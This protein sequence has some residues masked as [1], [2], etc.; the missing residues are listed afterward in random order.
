MVKNNKK[1]LNSLIIFLNIQITQCTSFVNPYELHQDED[2]FNG[3]KATLS[4]DNQRLINFNSSRSMTCQHVKG[5]KIEFIYNFT[6]YLK[7]MKFL[8]KTFEFKLIQI[9][10]I[11]SL[12]FICSDPI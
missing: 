12:I 4:M 9:N 3:M 2:Y 11:R 7:K 8:T 5:V 1:L 10:L 6:I